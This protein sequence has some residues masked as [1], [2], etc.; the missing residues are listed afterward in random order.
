MMK[1]LLE[2]E[3]IVFLKNNKIQIAVILLFAIMGVVSKNAAYVLF[4]PLLLPMQIKS[5]LTWDELCKWDKY[6]GCLPV[7][8]KT[9]VGAKYLM[10]LFSS[11]FSIVLVTACFALMNVISGEP[12]QNML[13]YFGTAAAESLLL[14]ALMMP[15]DFKFGSTKGRAIYLI[16]TAVGIAAI[17]SAM[18][19][20]GQNLL[21]KI[22]NPAQMTLI[23]AAVSLAVF[24]A[25]WFI[26]V[27]FYESREL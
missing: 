7:E 4:I 9:I 16:V 21:A 18:L 10:I 12:I 3:L 5:V 22:S 26:S 2:K 6:A 25:S 11:L 24:A 14:P 15:F 13:V 8:K 1:G 27:K 20:N 23:L 17:G 19:E